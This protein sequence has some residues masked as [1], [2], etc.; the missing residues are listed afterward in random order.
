MTSLWQHARRTASVRSD[1][2]WSVDGNVYF[3]TGRPVDGK[4]RP[5]TYD[6]EA[7]IQHAYKSN[8]PIFALMLARQMVFSEAR[9]QFRQMR[10]GRPGDLF[11]LLTDG[12]IEVFDRNGN[13]LGFEWAKRVLR[14]TG[15]QPLS[16][17]ADR[18][19]NEARGFGAQLD[20]QTL[21][22]IRRGRA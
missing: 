21:L 11:A 13:E 7:K 16:S 18:L 1:D 3:G 4:E 5:L 15:G 22:L 9:F 17:I 6:F 12:L 2:W 20:D 10:N 8:G 19:L 14:E